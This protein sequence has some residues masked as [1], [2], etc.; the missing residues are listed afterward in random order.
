MRPVYDRYRSIKRLLAIA[1]NYHCNSPNIPARSFVPPAMQQLDID[2]ASSVST[3]FSL[4]APISETSGAGAGDRAYPSQPH[5]HLYFDNCDH[6]HGQNSSVSSCCTSI[7][8]SINSKASDEWCRCFIKFH[9]V[10]TFLVFANTC[11]SSG[12]PSY[13]TVYSKSGMSIK[14]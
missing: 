11:K 12:S 5:H 14:R 7:T 2:A 4:M 9:E 10:V 6:P 1:A 8:T 3:H 13:F